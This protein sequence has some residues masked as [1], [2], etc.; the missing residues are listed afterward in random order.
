VP[1]P[2]KRIR[3]LAKLKPDLDMRTWRVDNDEVVHSDVWGAKDDDPNCGKRL[4]ISIDFL[5]MALLK[6]NC[7]LLVEVHIHRTINNGYHRD[8]KQMRNKRKFFLLKQD[9]SLD[10]LTIPQSKTDHDN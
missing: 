8:L 4:L 5:K 3:R 9:G 1:R 2:G 7:E 6:S 10:C